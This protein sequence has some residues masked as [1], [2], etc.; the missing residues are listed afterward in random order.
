MY[1]KKNTLFLICLLPCSFREFLYATDN[2][3]LIEMLEKPEVPGFLHSQLLSW[4]KKYATIGGMPEVVNLYAQN[5]DIAV[6][7]YQGEYLMQKAKTI[8]G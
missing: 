1:L 2:S 8:S 4:F 3:Q 5:S 6:R 7:V